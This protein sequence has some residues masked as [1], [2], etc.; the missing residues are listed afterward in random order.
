M[1]VDSDLDIVLVVKEPSAIKKIYKEVMAPGFSDIAVD[2][3]IKSEEDFRQ[4]KDF[5]GVCFEAFNHGL[6]IYHD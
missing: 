4:R 5:G 6:R 1:T 3:I 2:W